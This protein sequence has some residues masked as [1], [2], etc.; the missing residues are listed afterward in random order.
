VSNVTCGLA[1]EQVEQPASRVEVIAMDEAGS[2]IPG[3]V[4]TVTDA[5]DPVST[6]R[7]GVTGREGQITLLMPQSGALVL[8]ELTGLMPVRARIAATKSQKCIVRAYLRVD[9]RK[10][11]SIE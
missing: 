1:V 3:A 10:T 5:S 7:V 8:I 11:I 6:P 9:P 2:P 4:V